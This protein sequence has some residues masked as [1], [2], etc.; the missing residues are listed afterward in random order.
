VKPCKYISFTDKWKICS[1]AI[2]FFVSER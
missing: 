1:G 2:F